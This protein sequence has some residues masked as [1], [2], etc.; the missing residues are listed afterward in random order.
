M[1]GLFLLFVRFSVVLEK[2]FELEHFFR[3]FENGLQNA[4][5][6]R[7]GTEDF[8]QVLRQKR[9]LLAKSSDLL[10]DVVHAR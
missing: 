7:D 5:D 4:E 9:M 6:L 1:D 8:F 3:I 2:G 10:V